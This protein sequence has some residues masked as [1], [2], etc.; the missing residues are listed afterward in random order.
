MINKLDTINE[1]VEIE[2]EMFVN[3]NGENKVSCQENKATFE[4]MRRAQFDAWS[5]EVISSYLLDLR[6]AK[7]EGRSLLREK[8]IRMME[9]TNPA[10]YEILKKELPPIPDEAK[11][12]ISKIWDELLPQTIRIRERF[13]EINEGGRPL[14]SEDE[15]DYASIET[16][17]KGELSTYSLNTLKALYNH[18]I[19]L[20]NKGI[21]IAFEIQK[22]SITD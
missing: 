1:I 21:D 20:K 22:N 13:P 6:K 16:Y 12:L 8:Y 9:H 4:K 17:Q 3:V 7:E 11:D 15:N 2:W 19:D 10:D 18:I 5:E 14:R